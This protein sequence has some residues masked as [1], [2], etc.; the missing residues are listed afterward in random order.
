MACP[1]V[2]AFIL[3]ARSEDVAP[4]VAAVRGRV[5]WNQ[6]AALVFA[7][8]RGTIARHSRAGKI[9]PVDCWLARGRVPGGCGGQQG[10]TGAALRKA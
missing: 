9:S 2:G 8:C 1:A 4:I 5:F 6:R 10:L 7:S 3:V